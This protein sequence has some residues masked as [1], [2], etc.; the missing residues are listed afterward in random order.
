M[1]LPFSTTLASL[2]RASLLTSTVAARGARSIPSSADSAG[3]TIFPLPVKTA[4]R[5]RTVPPPTP[6]HPLGELPSSLPAPLTLRFDHVMSLEPA[7]PHIS[8]VQTSIPLTTPSPAE[9]STTPEALR[10]RVTTFIAT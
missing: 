10:Q 2:P 4:I 3:G 9:S 6:P 8:P 7:L 5:R 1:A